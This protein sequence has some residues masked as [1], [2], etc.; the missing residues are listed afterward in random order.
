[1]EKF[2][3]EN[4][5][6]YVFQF[7]KLETNCYILESGGEVGVIDPSATTLHEKETLFLFIRSLNKKLKYIINTHGHFDHIAA[8]GFLKNNFPLSKLAIHK[9]DAEMLR[10]PELNGSKN[11]GITVI[12]P[13]A[14]I[15][16]DEGEILKIGNIS[17]KVLHIPGHTSGSI[18]LY[19]NGFVFTG[20][21]LFSG[22][23]GIAKNFKNAFKKMIE[24]IKKKL[25]V[26]PDE[27]VIFPGH[28]EES[29]IGEE[30]RFNPFLQD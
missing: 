4:A 26:L 20:D 1:M 24:G 17:L 13:D 14:N 30:K 16:I 22:T 10:F 18:A 6:I 15:F 21:T 2:E 19:E 3:F 7:G 28:N 23:V 8:N 25:L 12:S 27:T 11:F 5:K 9:E 29:T